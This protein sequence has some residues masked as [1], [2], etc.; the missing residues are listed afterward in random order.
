MSN[1]FLYIDIIFLL[2]YVA[3]TYTTLNERRLMAEVTSRYRIP[4]SLNEDENKL[5]TKLKHKVEED[6]NRRFSL[7]ET[8]RMSI[9]ELAKTKGL[10]NDE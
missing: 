7:A 10:I 6:E 5:L 3:Y 4:V 8:V 9:R 1:I 2:K